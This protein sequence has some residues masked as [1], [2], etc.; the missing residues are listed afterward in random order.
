MASEV[1]KFLMKQ[2]T[3][4]IDEDDSQSSDA[5]FA[6]FKDIS[7]KLKSHST[8]LSIPEK[9]S[10]LSDLNDALTEWRILKE[11]NKSIRRIFFCHDRVA[12]FRERSAINGRLHDIETSIFPREDSSISVKSNQPNSLPADDQNPSY[13]PV[14][15]PYIEVDKFSNELEKKMIGWLLTPGDDFTAVGICGM[16]GSGKTALIKNVLE[17]KAVTDKFKRIIW[18][19]LSDFISCEEEIDVRVVEYLLYR[20]GLDTD[21]VVGSFDENKDGLM[22]ELV[23]QLRN[24]ENYILVLDDMWHCSD[25]FADHFLSRL[26]KMKGGA[27][28]VTSRRKT[29]ARKFGGKDRL[30]HLQPSDYRESASPQDIET[31]FQPSTSK[32]NQ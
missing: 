6:R 12:R 9:I 18:A 5:I 16:S 3:D 26:K 29:V 7:E 1:A 4:S 24:S 32:L 17:Q 23:R 27:A 15:T 28:I 14:R 30:I 13:S 19:P 8:A 31:Q 22:E 2:Y 20:L 11:Q 21:S 10:C 25:W